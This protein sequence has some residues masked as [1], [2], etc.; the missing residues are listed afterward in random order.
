MVTV[1]LLIG[2]TI[3]VVPKAVPAPPQKVR[4]IL[5][6]ARYISTSIIC[7]IKQNLV[8]KAN[9]PD[10]RPIEEP[11]KKAL[12]KHR[13]EIESVIEATTLMRYLPQVF[14]EHEREVINSQKYTLHRSEMF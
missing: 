5:S 14:T 11:G 7:S 13:T 1:A 8:H 9:T 6:L 10:A 2:G 12:L 3:L 4:T